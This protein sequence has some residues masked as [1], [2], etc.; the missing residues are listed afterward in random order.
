M[1]VRAGSA[2]LR[3][4]PADDAPMETQLL[5][6][7]VFTVYEDKDGWAWGQAAH[8]QYTGYVQS[9]V[10]APLGPLPTHT[11]VVSRSFVYREADIKSPPLMWLSMNA[12]LAINAQNE[13][14]SRIENIGWIY[15][16]H[17]APVGSFTDDFVSAA[18]IFLGAPY[19]WGGKDGLGMDCSGLLQTAMHRAGLSCP[20]DS[21]MQA[22]LGAP[23]PVDFTGAQ[24]GD[25][26]FWQGHVAIMRGAG[27]LLHANAYHMQVASEPLAPAVARIAKTGAMVT[28]VRRLATLGG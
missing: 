6:G 2:P 9:G 21:D 23:R 19:L 11:V 16:A 1:Q 28:G 20:R 14:F 25:L 10:L 7:E 8:D 17:L 5:F 3:H 27:M 13:G 18:E 24:R 15:S 26:I 12:R 4:A 22:N